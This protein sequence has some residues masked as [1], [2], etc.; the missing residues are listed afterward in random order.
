MARSYDDLV[1]RRRPLPVL[2][3]PAALLAL[4]MIVLAVMTA[5]VLVERDE[6]VRDGVL[7]RLGHQLESALRESGPEEAAEVLRRFVSE[8]SGAVSG[9]ELM[10]RGALVSAAGSVKGS[11]VEMPAFLGR[12]WRSIMMGAGHWGGGGPMG[13]PV[14]LKIYPAS[15][16][17]GAQTLAATVVGTSVIAGAGL[18]LLALVAAR[19]LV[20]RQELAV[21][22]SERRRLE[23]VSLAGAGLAHKIRN[24]LAVIKGT[25]QMLAGQLEGPARERARRIVESSERIEG[26]IKRLLD[27]ARPPERQPESFDLVPLAR[28][29]VERLDGKTR[30]ELDPRVTVTADRENVVSILEEL[31]ANARAFDP[32]GE[33]EV[34]V[35]NTSGGAELLVSDRGP[36][37]QLPIAQLFQPYVTSRA[38]GTGLGLAIVKA[39]TEA[40]GLEISL[41]DRE[42]GGCVANLRF[43]AGRS[44]ED[45][46]D[47]GR[48]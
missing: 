2:T 35:R 40:N 17:G 41:G 6:A 8:N 1:F 46:P 31:L 20:T 24:P 4:G 30:L 15:A 29:V 23:S 42:G 38:E 37:L 45:G 5:R 32:E 18:V 34:T 48:R 14:R 47:S 33:I 11:A 21:A 26:L 10:A 9:V 3:I 7:L 44:E 39:L 16:A 22:A 25:S 43:P 19:N 36:G 12:E 28:E 13:S 27:F